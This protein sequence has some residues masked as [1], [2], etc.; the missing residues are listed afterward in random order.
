MRAPDT[1]FRCEARSFRQ[2]LPSA[3][4]MTPRTYSYDFRVAL[5]DIDA[6]GVMFFAHLFR[7]AHDAYESFMTDIGQ[8]LDRLIREGRVR[9]P[10]VH[11]QADYRAP[12]RHGQAV[13]I[14]LAVARVGTRSFTLDYR[15]IAED[16]QLLA[17]AQTVHAHLEGD[18]SVPLPQGLA[19]A[20]EDRCGRA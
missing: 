19:R 5:H 7:Y 20:L 6:G 9:L 4:A 15:F 2:G 17:L 10:L 18:A 14:R 11:V 1:D 16:G 12:L 13:S 8:P 3:K